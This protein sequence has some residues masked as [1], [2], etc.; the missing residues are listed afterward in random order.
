V[1]VHTRWWQYTA[2]P[3]LAAIM[4]PAQLAQAAAAALAAS[5][6]AMDQGADADADAHAA[7]AADLALE[8]QA[9]YAIYDGHCGVR[10]AR[11]ARV[12][13]LPC[14]HAVLPLFAFPAVRA[15]NARCHKPP[16]TLPRRRS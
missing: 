1:N 16:I 6:T 4:E 7:V 10:A 2:I 8:A 11:Y 13:A 3:D 15:P 14:V 12:C 9:F 5:A